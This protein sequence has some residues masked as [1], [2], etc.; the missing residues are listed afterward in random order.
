MSIEEIDAGNFL[1]PLEN[2]E[3]IFDYVQEESMKAHDLDSN[4]SERVGPVLGQIFSTVDEAYQFYNTYALHKGFEIR[5]G[6]VIRSR[7]TNEVIRKK[8][9]CCKEGKKYLAD[10]RQ[11]GKDVKYRRDTRT[12]CKAKIEITMKNGEWLVDKFSDVHNHDL[13][14]TPSKVI[15]YRSHSKFHRTE[16][17]KNLISELNQSGLKPSDI[18]RVVNVVSGSSE[19]DITPRQCYDYLK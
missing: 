13:T 1:V 9:V 12:D 3:S 17:C 4:K 16:S 8:F 2:D 7:V 15:K 19:P 14:H 18:T 11:V 5:I 6:D 10:K